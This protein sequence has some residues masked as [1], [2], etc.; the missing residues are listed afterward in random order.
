MVKVLDA[1]AVLLFFEKK[2]GYELVRQLFLESAGEKCVLLITAVNWGE[3]RYILLQKCGEAGFQKA[4]EALQ[5]LPVRIVD[6]DRELVSVAGD[7]KIKYKLGYC[8]A[9]AAALAKINKAECVTMDNDFSV[10]KN[11]IKVSLIR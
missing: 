2:P 5:S 4:M 1:S 10:L 11:E 8:D 3:V 9:M 6:V 7:L